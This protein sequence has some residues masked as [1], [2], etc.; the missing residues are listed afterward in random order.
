MSNVW[1]RRLIA[2]TVNPETSPR[3]RASYS[4]WMLAERAPSAWLASQTSH[5]AAA[6]VASSVAERRGPGEVRDGAVAEGGFVVDDEPVTVEMGA[7]G[8]G[9]QQVGG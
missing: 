8:E 2:G 4:P 5:C 9:G 3:A 6:V 1:A 7:P